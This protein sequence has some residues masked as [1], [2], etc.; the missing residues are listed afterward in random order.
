MAAQVAGRR[1]HF[2]G[3][4]VE[5]GCSPLLLRWRCKSLR[6]LICSLQTNNSELPMRRFEPR[7]AAICN[8]FGPVSKPALLERRG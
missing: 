7:R 2:A 8:G 6:I 5:G 4:A 3:W 1:R